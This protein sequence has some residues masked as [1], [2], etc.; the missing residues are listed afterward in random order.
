MLW[1]HFWRFGQELVSQNCGDLLYWVGPDQAQ[2][3]FSKIFLILPAYVQ[4]LQPI[5]QMKYY[6]RSHLIFLI[7]IRIIHSVRFEVY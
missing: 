4:S 3:A 5:L 6:K 1:E 7:L 2:P